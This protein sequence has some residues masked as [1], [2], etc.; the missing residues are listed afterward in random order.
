MSGMDWII[1]VTARLKDVFPFNVKRCNAPPSPI[2]TC[3]D[4]SRDRDGS[5]LI[6]LLPNFIIY[7]NTC[8]AIQ[9]LH[10]SKLDQTWD[11]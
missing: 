6:T 7:Q 9:A 2:G 5:T 11:G 4:P 10:Y 3:T 1:P 8:Y